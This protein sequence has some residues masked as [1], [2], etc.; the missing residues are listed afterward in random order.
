MAAKKKDTVPAVL[1]SRA[2]EHGSK[3]F[4][5]QYLKPGVT[6][7]PELDLEYALGRGS[8]TGAIELLPD[9]P[10][11]KKIPWDKPGVHRNVALAKLRKPSN[12]APGDF[13]VEEN[14]AP[15]EPDEARTHIVRRMK[16]LGL[17]GNDI[18]AVEAMLGPSFTL[19][20]VVEGLEGMPDRWWDNGGVGGRMHSLY[21]LM[22]RA[23]PEETRAARARLEA[24]PKVKKGYGLLALDLMLRG[25]PAITEHGYKYDPKFKCYATGAG[26]ENPSNVLDLCF[27]ENESEWIASQFAKLWE[28]FKYKV[29]NHMNGPSPARLFWLGGEPLFETELK[30]VS[31]YPGTKQAQALASYVDFKSPG[32]ARCV[33]S[34]A[35]PKSKV[36]KQ[37]AAWLEAQ[38]SWVKT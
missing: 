38:A 28:L 26:D 6:L 31:Q 22:L 37:A 20:A 5:A 18:R 29:Q 2:Y 33:R 4:G 7:S 35:G 3:A 16:H 9:L 15:L 36:A 21:G 8:P 34:L 19:D 17:D 10:P 14:P 25:R 27:C 12:T 11:G 1:P 30:V 32:A 24:L 13:Q 23:L